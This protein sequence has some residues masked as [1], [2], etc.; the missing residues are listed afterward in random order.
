MLL[1]TVAWLNCFFLKY[2]EFMFRQLYIHKLTTL[3]HISPE[4]NSEKANQSTASYFTIMCITLLT[5]LTLI[6]IH[7]SP[8]IRYVQCQLWSE[9]NFR[10]E[11]ICCRTAERLWTL[12]SCIDL[13]DVTWRQQRFWMRHDCKNAIKW[14]PEWKKNK[15]SATLF[16]LC[17]FLEACADLIMKHKQNSSEL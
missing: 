5:V 14:W 12:E 10:I 3:L 6:Q 17:V 4:N 9:L 2:F 8:S 7:I 13:S 15:V 11:N 1:Y 16:S